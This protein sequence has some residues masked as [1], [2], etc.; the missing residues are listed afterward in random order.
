MRRWKNL[1][2]LPPHFTILAAEL[3]AIYLAIQHIAALSQQP[4]TLALI[5]DSLSSFKTFQN[6]RQHHQHP[7]AKLIV[8]TLSNMEHTKAVF[9]CVPSHCDI[10]GNELGDIAARQLP[11]ANPLAAMKDVGRTI[12]S[13]LT[14]KWHQNWKT[15]DHPNLKMFKRTPVPW[16]A[17]IALTCRQQVVLNRVRIGHTRLTHSYLFTGRLRP[18]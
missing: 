3:S 11:H 7:T 14:A 2:S 10:P 17:N 6:T 1:D 16:S 9:L 13:K 18:T 4:Q 15:N 5:S 8:R 12:R